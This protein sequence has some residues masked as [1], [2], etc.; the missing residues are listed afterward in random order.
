[1]VVPV[2]VRNLMPQR[3]HER[4]LVTQLVQLQPEL[5]G[6]VVDAGKPRGRV[7]FSRARRDPRHRARETERLRRASFLEGV[8][9]FHALTA[10]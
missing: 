7:G 10:Q 9:R 3:C 5:A 8:R 4:L 2:G 1:M 6:L